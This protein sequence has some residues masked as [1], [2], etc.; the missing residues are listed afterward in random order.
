MSFRRLSGL[1]NFFTVKD[2]LPLCRQSGRQRVP[3]C[4]RLIGGFHAD[5]FKQQALPGLWG[6]RAAD[7]SQS[8]VAE[9]VVDI[10][11][12]VAGQTCELDDGEECAFDVSRVRILEGIHPPRG[13]VRID[14]LVHASIKRKPSPNAAK[15][16]SPR[17]GDAGARSN[18][19]AEYD[20]FRG[21]QVLE[22]RRKT[23]HLSETFG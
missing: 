13:M 10:T 18:A 17:A 6:V 7:S 16:P 1:P 21:V 22:C 12:A 14:C 15:S 23:N 8:A 19:V 2:L 4:A 9:G 5:D 3:K 20:L 11:G